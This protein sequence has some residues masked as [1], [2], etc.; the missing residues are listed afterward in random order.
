MEPLAV[1]FEEKQYGRDG[2]A[3]SWGL[4]CVKTTC[5][6]CHTLQRLEAHEALQAVQNSGCMQPGR[7]LLAIGGLEI[8]FVAAQRELRC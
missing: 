8:W 3:V 7:G 5:P 2:A 4:Y 1:E 6:H